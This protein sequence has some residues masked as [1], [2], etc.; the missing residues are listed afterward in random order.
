MGMVGWAS[1]VNYSP[2]KVLKIKGGGFRQW[3]WFF[4]VVRW[5]FRVLGLG[6]REFCG[7]APDGEQDDGG[8]G[9]GDEEAKPET[10]G[11]EVG[12]EAEQDA[13]WHANDPVTDQVGVKRREGV[14]CSAQGA[15]DGDLDAVEELKAGGHEK[16]RDGGGDDAAV[17]REDTREQAG[18]REKD[19]GGE[20]HEGGSGEDATPTGG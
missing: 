7:A 9:E 2:F 20:E 19:D 6:K 16:Q 5:Q 13:E 8:S 1:Q 12:A 14:A 3:V 18:Q 15:G 11:S 17:G 10:G 4:G